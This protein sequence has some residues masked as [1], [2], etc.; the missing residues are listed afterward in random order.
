AVD[1]IGRYDID[2]PLPFS[3]SDHDG[4]DLK[5]EASHPGYNPGTQEIEDFDSGLIPYQR[6]F[7][8]VPGK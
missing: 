3:W 1:D 6:D 4:H 7:E 8:L 5:G 2:P